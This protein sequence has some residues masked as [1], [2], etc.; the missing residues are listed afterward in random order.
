MII[1]RSN[2]DNHISINDTGYTDINGNL[3]VDGSIKTYGSLTNVTQ[4]IDN[5]LLYG[6]SSLYFS[7]L[8]GSP[9]TNEKAQI[10]TGNS[11]GLNINTLTNHNISFKAYSDQVGATDSLRILSTREVEIL[12]NLNIKCPLTTIDNAITM[13]GKL[14]CS[15]INPVGTGGILF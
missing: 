6:Y 3:N 4:S 12:G 8:S 11:A 7:G 2:G 15:N 5:N 14:T 13:N 10:F 1:K 9:S